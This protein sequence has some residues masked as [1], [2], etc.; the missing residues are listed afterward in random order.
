[1]SICRNVG[2]CLALAVLPL[3]ASAQQKAR[4]DPADPKISVPTVVY[5]S[6]LKQYRP[7]GDEQIV[8]WKAT[9]DL[10][11]KIGGWRV[12]AKE[13]RE[14]EP[15]VEQPGRPSQRPAPQTRPPAQ[16]GHSGHKMN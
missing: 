9:N 12:Y 8:S 13:A 16:G 2:L 6:S 4:P 1:M 3:L 14:P 10:V 15:T 5:V 7:L 11:E